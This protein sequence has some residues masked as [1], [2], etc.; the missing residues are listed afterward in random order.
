MA[1]R[2]VEY[3]ANT[4]DFSE[5]DGRAVE[6]ARALLREVEVVVLPIQEVERMA[7]MVQT[8]INQFKT[9]QK[10]DKDTR[11]K[12]SRNAEQ[13]AEAPEMFPVALQAYPPHFFRC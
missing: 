2:E 8:T 3:V 4:V 7:N 1:A 9:P 11:E 6:L 5:E 10:E 12:V 13:S